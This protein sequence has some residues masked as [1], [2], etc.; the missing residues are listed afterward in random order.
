LILFFWRYCRIWERL[1]TEEIVTKVTDEPKEPKVKKD[2]QFVSQY[3]A[4]LTA[5]LP[6]L[7]LKRA[8]RILQLLLHGYQKK[9]SL[10]DLSFK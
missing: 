10:A 2:P 6:T 1:A 7:Y 3:L 9:S 5:L 8:S 4:I